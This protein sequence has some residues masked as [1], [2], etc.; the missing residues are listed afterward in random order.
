[1]KKTFVVLATVLLA[2]N[3]HAGKRSGGGGGKGGGGKDPCTTYTLVPAQGPAVVADSSRRVHYTITPGSVNG[4]VQ[5]IE[6][7]N[8]TDSAG[9]TVAVKAAGADLSDSWIEGLAAGQ[10]YTFTPVTTGCLG[11]GAPVSITM[12]ADQPETIAPSITGLSVFNRFV[13]IGSIPYIQIAVTDATGI[14]S[15]SAS[16]DGG[17]PSADYPIPAAGEYRVW[18]NK[19]SNLMVDNGS[20]VYMQAPQALIGTGAHSVTVEVVD[21]FGNRSSMSAQLSF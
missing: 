2:F 21:V 8:V 18:T 11:V 16:I 19:T 10:T 4:I 5:G 15:F 1:M 13:F 20:H 12:P 17:A 14:G 6:L 9:V 7:I 3:A